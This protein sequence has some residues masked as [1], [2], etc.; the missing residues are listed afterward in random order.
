[1]EPNKPLELNQVEISDPTGN[2]VSNQSTLYW[3]LS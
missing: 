1:M 2:Q 3:S